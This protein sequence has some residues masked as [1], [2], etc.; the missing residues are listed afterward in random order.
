MLVEFST[1]MELIGRQNSLRRF[2]I[3]LLGL[4]LATGLLIASLWQIEI[5]VVLPSDYFDFPFYIWRVDKWW[6]RDFWYMIN[7]VSWILGIV[8]VAVLVNQY[9]TNGEKD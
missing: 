6:V 1:N 4:I 3:P 7:V 9:K 2:M 8:S 5:A